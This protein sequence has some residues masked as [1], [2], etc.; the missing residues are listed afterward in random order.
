VSYF[1]VNDRCNGCLACVQ[2][3]PACALD[4]RDEGSKRTLLHNMA[5]CARC[6]TCYRVCPEKAVEF[7]HLLESGW[8]E[9]ASFDL[10]RCTECGAPLRTASLPSAIETKLAPLAEALCPAHRAR[11][12]GSTLAAIRQD[13]D[14]R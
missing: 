13:H 6:A 14:R 4:F 5:R 2:N 10:V 1:H 3:C 8:D 9:V 11:R 12:H 7:V